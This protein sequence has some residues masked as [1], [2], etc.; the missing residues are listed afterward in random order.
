MASRAVGSR[1]GAN[2]VGRGL[3]YMRSQS[4][5]PRSGGGKSNST[6]L[7]DIHGVETEHQ[8]L[9]RVERMEGTRSPARDPIGAHHRAP[10]RGDQILNHGDVA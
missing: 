1:E 6:P 10:G 5:K 7:R 2:E 8:V 3:I 9:R 4:T